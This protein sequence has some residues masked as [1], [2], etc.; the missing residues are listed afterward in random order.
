MDFT[1]FE[2]SP[3]DLQ[4]IDNLIQQLHNWVVS[5]VENSLVNTCTVDNLSIKLNEELETITISNINFPSNKYFI[6]IILSKPE[7]RG[8]KKARKRNELFQFLG[9][10]QQALPSI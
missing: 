6:D 10:L 4:F 3:E 1:N 9:S 7:M 2:L 5:I 8:I